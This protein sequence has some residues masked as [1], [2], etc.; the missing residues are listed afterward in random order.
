MACGIGSTDLA[1]VM[2]T[3][4]IWLKVPETIRIICNGVLQEGVTAKDLILY[5]VGKVTISGATYQS[6]EFKGEAFENMTLASRMSVANMIAEMGG[7]TGFIHPKGLQ[8]DYDFEAITA[9]KNATYSKTFEF[10]ISG[11]EP[12]ISVPESP[13]NVENLGTVSYT[14]LTLPTTP[15][16]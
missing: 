11:L 8:L 2:K 15:Y 1:A 3:G 13:D 7:K 9:D 6:V 10:D 14:H 12:Q 5:L 4:M 16:V